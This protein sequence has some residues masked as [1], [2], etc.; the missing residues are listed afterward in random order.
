MIIFKKLW[1]ELGRLLS[2]TLVG[3]LGIMYLSSFLPRGRAVAPVPLDFCLGPSL[4]PTLGMALPPF[5]ALLRSLS[6]SQGSAITSPQRNPQLYLTLTPLFRHRR[7]HASS[8]LYI[9][10]LQ[11]FKGVICCPKPPHFQK[12]PS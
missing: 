4:Y 9:L 3:A 5:Q 11:P 8:S 7:P 6:Y 1:Q 2:A 10:P 12:P